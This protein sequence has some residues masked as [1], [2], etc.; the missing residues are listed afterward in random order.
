MSHIYRDLNYCVNVLVK[1]GRDGDPTRFMLDIVP[2]GFLFSSLARFLLR[3]SM[4]RTCLFIF[5]SEIIQPETQMSKA[6]CKEI[7]PNTY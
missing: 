3:S 7:K 2:L 1:M 6:K 4:L 5:Y